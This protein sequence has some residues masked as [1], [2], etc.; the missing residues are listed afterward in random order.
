MIRN[1]LGLK[2]L[3]LFL[4]FFSLLLLLEQSKNLSS[5]CNNHDLPLIKYRYFFL[6]VSY[7]DLT[8]HLHTNT[9]AYNWGL[10]TSTNTLRSKKGVQTFTPLKC[11]SWSVSLKTAAAVILTD[12][13]CMLFPH[14]Y[15]VCLILQIVSMQ[16]NSLYQH[17]CFRAHGSL[18]QMM[19]CNLPLDICQHVKCKLISTFCDF[20]HLL[21]LSFSCSGLT[22]TRK[23]C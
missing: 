18:K 16:Q 6:P 4:F 9:L 22:F 1:T 2:A 5:V 3:L 11:T 19:K 20:H 17:H 15:A 23:S 8:N 7:F 12:R 21:I 14:I 10:P 13:D